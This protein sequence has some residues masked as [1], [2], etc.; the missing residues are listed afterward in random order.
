MKYG[1]RLQQAMHLADK[2]RAGVAQATHR[3]VQAIGQCITGATSALTAENNARAAAFLEV[4]CFWLATG[5][6]Q[7]RPDRSWPFK[8]FL[9][10]QYFALEQ[11][12]RDE[13]EERLLGRIT[14]DERVQK[15]KTKRIA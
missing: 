14:M 10:S 7:P 13:I 1:E 3:T 2:D 12:L 9:P 11:K 8:S 4:D 15:E 6:G 5:E